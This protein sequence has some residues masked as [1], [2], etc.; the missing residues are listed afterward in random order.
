MSRFLLLLFWKMIK[1]PSGNRTTSIVKEFLL[2]DYH[3]GSD[4]GWSDLFWFRTFPS[5]DGLASPSSSSSSWK[6]TF[7]VYGDLGN[8]NAQSLP[9]LQRETQEGMYDLVM[10][11]GDFAYDLHSVRVFEF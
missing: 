8:A 5:F 10:H 1:I 11:V 4:L 2:S 3:V 9:R 7:A 6:A